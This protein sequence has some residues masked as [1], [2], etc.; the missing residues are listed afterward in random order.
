VLNGIR[1]A[2]LSITHKLWLLLI[3]LIYSHHQYVGGLVGNNSSYRVRGRLVSGSITS[4]FWD[5]ETSGELNMCGLQDPNATGCDNS[6]GKTAVEMKQ[7]ST[8]EGSDFINVWGIGENQTHPYL[9]KYSAADIN[10]DETVNF[11]DLAILADNWLTD[12]TP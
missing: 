10:E 9:R 4:S 3:I 11:G 8:F 12:S 1:S 5:I 7:Q 6:Y 2:K